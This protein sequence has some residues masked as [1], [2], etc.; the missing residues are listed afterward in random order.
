MADNLLNITSGSSLLAKSNIPESTG[1]I[2]LTII[3]FL[4][5]LITVVIIYNYWIIYRYVPKSISNENFTIDDAQIP[6][7][8]AKQSVDRT[9]SCGNLEPIVLATVA[10]AAKY[11]EGDM[12]PE[13]KR[14]YDENAAKQQNQARV[15]TEPKIPGASG[16]SNMYMTPQSSDIQ[17]SGSGPG[18]AQEQSYKLEPRQ[19]SSQSIVNQ[20]KI[21]KSA[22]PEPGVTKLIIFHMR[23]CGHCMDIMDRKQQNNKTKFEQLSDIFSTDPAVQVMDFQ[24]GRDKEAEKYNGFPV[25]LIVTIDGEEEYMGPRE[26]VNIAKAVI[27][28]K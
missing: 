28:K 21:K 3:L 4:L 23:G 9:E 16:I 15:Q 6:S 18:Q 19:T 1:K 5:G 2:T 27:N 25:I 14:Y 26:V 20:K 7:Q 22:V 24:Y 13:L 17:G 8:I 10:K 12:S 11:Q